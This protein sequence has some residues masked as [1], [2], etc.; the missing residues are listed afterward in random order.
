VVRVG[1]DNIRAIVVEDSE[2][3][4]G[5]LDREIAESK[6]A[7]KDPWKDAWLPEHDNQFASV[8]PILQ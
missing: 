6:A 4:A 2:G 7:Y 8:L 1:I 5:R 3:I